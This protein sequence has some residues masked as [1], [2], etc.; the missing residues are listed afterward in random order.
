[1]TA[2]NEIARVQ[3]SAGFTGSDQGPGG[4]MLSGLQS[5]PVWKFGAA[6][7]PTRIAPIA[8]GPA[9]SDGSNGV[10]LWITP[11]SDTSTGSTGWRTSSHVGDGWNSAPVAV[12]IPRSSAAA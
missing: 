8:I 12:L 3:T 9:V 2:M 5:S 11:I 7:A 1:M 6:N 4:V 10:W